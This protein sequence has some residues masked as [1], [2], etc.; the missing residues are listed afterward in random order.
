VDPDLMLIFGFALAAMW[1]IFRRPERLRR[2][3]RHRQGPETQE[4]QDS[5][6]ANRELLDQLARIEERVKVLERIVTDDPQELR[7]QFRNLAD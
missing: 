3:R 5:Q 1:I 2:R 6:E 7:R 4:A